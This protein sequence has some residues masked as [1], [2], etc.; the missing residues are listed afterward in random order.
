MGLD[1]EGSRGMVKQWKTVV[2]GVIFGILIYLTWL[3]AYQQLRQEYVEV[4]GCAS[5]AQQAEAAGSVMLGC[6]LK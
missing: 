6:S 2:A 1:N 4:T 5:L 3:L